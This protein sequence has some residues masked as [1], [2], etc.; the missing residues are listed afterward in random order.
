[1]AKV[2]SITDVYPIDSDVKRDEGGKPVLDEWGFVIPDRESNADALRSVMRTFFS[3]GVFADEGDELAVTSSGGTWSVGTGVA[4]A[5]GLRI[6]VKKPAEVISQGEIGT[7]QYAYIIIAARFETNYR[8]GA[9]YAV[10]A[11]STTY[12]PVRDGSTYELVLARVDWRG[13]IRDLRLDP[14]MCGAAAPFMDVDTD[15]FM[16]ALYTALSQFNLN[17]GDVVALPVGSDPEVVVRKPDEA[18]GDVYIDFKLPKGVKGETGATGAQGPQG[19]QGPRG[20]QGPKGETGATGPQGPQ[21]IQGPKGDKGD[22]GDP[23]ES[24][25]YTQMSGFFAVGV[26]PD[27]SLFATY[28]DGGEAPPISLDG[29][30]NLVYDIPEE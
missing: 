3:S 14:S 26:D 15:S 6:P 29:D 27:G 25:V 22:K 9:I 17:I 21:G 19:E 13:E 10:V 16:L 18:G 4:I 2:T 12:E 8:D 11:D 30:G 23:G 5:D 1:M 24:G 28:A 7:G 20:I